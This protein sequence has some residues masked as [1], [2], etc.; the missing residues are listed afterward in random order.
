MRKL[1]WRLE[2][3]QDGLR[4]LARQIRNEP[5]YLLSALDAQQWLRVGEKTEESAGDVCVDG[6]GGE[7]KL[8]MRCIFGVAE[9]QPGHFRRRL[10]AG[11]PM[12]VELILQ[13]LGGDLPL[14]LLERADQP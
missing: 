12:P 11:V 1:L 2:P 7:Q 13:P 6:G 3:R 10:D 4:R 14:V 9:K 8:A 5:G